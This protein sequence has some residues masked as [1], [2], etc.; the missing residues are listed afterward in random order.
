MMRPL[1]PPPVIFLVG[2]TASGKTAASLALAQRHGAEVVNADSRQVY[3][4]MDIGTAKPS[5]DERASAPHHLLDLA[6]PDE[7]YSLATFLSQAREAITGIHGRGRLPLVVGGT[8]QYV[9]GLAEG[10]QVPQVPPQRE[11]RERLEHEA[12]ELGAEALHQRLQRVDA[13]A[14][15]AID[16][17]NVRRVVRALEVW[18]ATGQ[19]FSTQRGRA[20]PPFTPHV[21][22]LWVP[23]QELHRRIGARIEAMVEAGWVQEVQRLLKRGYAPELP[24]FSSAGYREIAAYLQGRTDWREAIDRTNVA[25]HRLARRQGAWFR[26]TDPRIRWADD[27]ESFIA[28]ASRLIADGMVESASGK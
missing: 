18:E 17:R 5:A 8:G 20:A 22:G 23:R 14:A 4:G 7:P 6:D 1:Y 24:S 12:R 25:V 16:P 19:R 11:L 27:G 9:W 2:A 21:L 26:R 13:V 10:W 28:Q 15:Q 3:R